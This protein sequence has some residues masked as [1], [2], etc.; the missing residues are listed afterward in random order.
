MPTPYEQELLRLAAQQR[1]ANERAQAPAELP[2]LPP[3]MFTSAAGQQELRAMQ[4]GLPPPQGPHRAPQRQ[5][6]REEV[7][8]QRV[9]QT[10]A[11]PPPGVNLES[12]FM[13]REAQDAAELMGYTPD[14]N[15]Q[16]TTVAPESGFDVEFDMAE[17]DMTVPRRASGGSGGRVVSQ[18]QADGSWANTP[19]PMPQNPPPLT[20]NDMRQ[21]RD[22]IERQHQR[23]PFPRDLP[24]PRQMMQEIRGAMRELETRAP[25]PP[26]R[27]APQGPARSIYERVLDDDIL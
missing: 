12:L 3:G 18:R 14:P 22:Q 19:R 16:M 7:V 1:L 21:M 26:P 10:G 15:T 17:L 23:N 24:L 6:T 27:R 2:D 4:G 25:A 13:N 8:A 11:Q 20:A 5:M 9:A